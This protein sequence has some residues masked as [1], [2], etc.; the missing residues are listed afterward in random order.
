MRKHSSRLLVAASFV[1]AG[2]VVLAQNTPPTPPPP[3]AAPGPSLKT[4]PSPAEMTQLSVKYL[5][6][7]KEVLKR[8]VK[9]QGVARSQKDVIKLN[10]VNDKL[11][12]IK[13]LLNIGDLASTNM[14]EA[15]VRGDEEARVSEFDRITISQQQVNILAGEAENCVGGGD[16]VFVGPTKVIVDA[17]EEPDDPTKPPDVGLPTVEVPPVASPFI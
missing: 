13:Q 12:Q 14:Q 2:G 4:T 3:A 5:D 15:I 17:P 8:V 7:E 16:L 1:L 9:L 11:L 10:C 6:Q